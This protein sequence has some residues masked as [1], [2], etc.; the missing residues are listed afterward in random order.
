MT[1]ETLER[2]KAGQ[3]SLLS[4]RGISKSFGPVEALRSVDLELQRGELLG[5]IGHNG[6][7]KSTLM[8]V[9]M[10]VVLPDNGTLSMD[11]SLVT[12]DNHPSRAHTL[13]IRC[14]FQ[15]LSLC[16]NLSA[17]ENTLVVHPHLGG[18]GWEK[19]SRALIA[20]TLGEIFPGNRIKLHAPISELAIGERQMIEIARAFTESDSPAKL[21]ILDEP[22]SSLDASAA[23]QLLAYLRRASAAGRSC[24]LIT[25]K[26]NE[27]LDHTQRIV[28]MKDGRI[29]ADVPAAGLSRERLFELMGAVAR[30]ET[31]PTGSLVKGN[32]RI[33]I[34]GLDG[35]P[36]VHVQAGEVVGLA[37]LAGHGQK[38]TLRRIYRTARTRKGDGQCRVE[39]GA[40]YVSGDRQREGIFP[41]WSIALN[42]SIA[43]MRRLARRGFIDGVE[44]RDLAERWRQKV[45]IRS[46]GPDQSIMALSGGNRQKA[47]VARA[48][49]S[50]SEII[51]FDD[52]T[53]GVDIGTKREIY[54]QI[55]AEAGSGRSFVWY[56]TENDELF[57]CDR[58]YVFHERRVVDVIDRADLTEDRLI[59][60]SFEGH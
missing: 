32:L 26:L 42:V 4:L 52:P 25:H 49:A 23:E 11:G 8:N 9:L 10:G 18:L 54:E 5:L 37:G 50:T 19:R 34:A 1:V 58:V 43:S 35:M 36:A 55:R 53:R 15:E 47:L 29:V 28:T 41:L 20:H 51:L 57:L 33:E 45:G 7:G 14:V 60:A 48:F 38:D 12:G 17:I 31:T 30:A 2:G 21:V 56:T 59:R 44:E 16:P 22:T 46:S 27:V 40:A 3:A 24:I 13:G 39:G 6:A